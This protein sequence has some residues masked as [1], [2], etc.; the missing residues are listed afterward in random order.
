MCIPKRYRAIAEHDNC[1]EIAAFRACGAQ[2]NTVM[3]ALQ[4]T[5]RTTLTHLS[6]SVSESFS[7]SST[8]ARN[9]VV[10]GACISSFNEDSQ[11]WES[12][13][14]YILK[15]ACSNT[16]TIVAMKSWIIFAQLW[17]INGSWHIILT[18]CVNN[19]I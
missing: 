18:I 3:K 11:R 6:R 4:N 5:S 13:E 10:P 14:T 8:V 15:A 7:S 17:I 9:F 12:S 2:A 19:H 16:A 1:Y